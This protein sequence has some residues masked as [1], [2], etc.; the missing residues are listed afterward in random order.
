[1]NTLFVP[2]FSCALLWIS[3]AIFSIGSEGYLFNSRHFLYFWPQNF[4]FEPDLLARGVSPNDIYL[5]QNCT[6]SFSFVFFVWLLWRIY[7]ECNRKIAVVTP[8]GIVLFLAIIPFAAIGSIIGF[9]D[10]CTPT[11]LCYF[12][13]INK[14]I[15]VTTAIM[16]LL[17]MSAGEILAK[18]VAILRIATRELLKMARER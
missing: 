18:F 1:M 14:N 16:F 15:F 3:T 2:I 7:F 4:L 12:S 11:N 13:N 9:K 10:V 5:F 17:Y 6:S 8:G